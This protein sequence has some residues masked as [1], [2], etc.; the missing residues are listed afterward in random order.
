MARRLTTNQEIAGSIPASINISVPRGGSIL[1]T[2]ACSTDHMSGRLLLNRL[3]K[4]VHGVN[5]NSRT[6][7]LPLPLHTHQLCLNLISWIPSLSAHAYRLP[8]RPLS[9]FSLLPVHTHHQSSSLDSR[10]LMAKQRAVV[11]VGSLSLL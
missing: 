3:L 10:Y 2:F 5:C 9:Q 6:N 4:V 7:V 11:C 8:S 1:L